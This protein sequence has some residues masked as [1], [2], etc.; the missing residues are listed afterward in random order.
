MYMVCVNV[1]KKVKW[2]ILCYMSITAIRKK[3]E[4]KQIS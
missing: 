3:K 4:W 2:Q 1:K